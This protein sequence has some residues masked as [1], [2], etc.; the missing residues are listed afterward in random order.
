MEAAGVTGVEM[1]ADADAAG[2]EV[3]EAAPDGTG[4]ATA[5]ALAAR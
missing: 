4:E 5:A 1:D 2:V 3:P